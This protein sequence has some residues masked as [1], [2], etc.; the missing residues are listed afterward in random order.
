MKLLR[1]VGA[2]KE[3]SDKERDPS[4]KDFVG[5]LPVET[6]IR[7]VNYLQSGTNFFDWME[8]PLDIF[9]EEPMPSSLSFVTDG[10]WM[11]RN[12][13]VQ[14][15]KKYRVGLPDEFT[16]FACINVTA[17]PVELSEEL[18]KRQPFGVL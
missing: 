5:M 10:V 6:A 15:V 17:K 11:W 16:E 13:L 8:W 18:F 7:I 14:Y 2:F 4:M 9:T 12:D 3:L 1:P